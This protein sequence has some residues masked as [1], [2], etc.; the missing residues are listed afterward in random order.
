[1][2]QQI[3]TSAVVG[4]RVG[5]Q[6][7][8]RSGNF[9]RSDIADL[10]GLYTFFGQW[11]TSIPDEGVLSFLKIKPGS[12]VAW[13]TYRHGVDASGGRNNL[14]VHAFVF[15]EEEL[16]LMNGDPFVLEDA[17]CFLT[18][19]TQVSPELPA[20]PAPQS[21][22]GNGD[23]SPLAALSSLQI[24]I[25]LAASLC[26]GYSYFDSEAVTPAH[27][28]AVRY[29][30]PGPQRNR[31]TFYGLVTGIPTRKAKLILMPSHRHSPG[32]D[33]DASAVACLQKGEY[34]GPDPT[35][36][37]SLMADYVKGRDYEAIEG[38]AELSEDF[39]VDVFAPEAGEVAT[40]FSQRQEYVAKLQTETIL[41][42]CESLRTTANAK[43]IEGYRNEALLAIARRAVDTAK[44]EVP[45]Q[46]AIAVLG[47]RE[48]G[49][50]TEQVADLGKVLQ[51]VWKRLGDYPLL[52]PDL[53]ESHDLYFEPA[54]A[55]IGSLLREF[56]QYQESVN[57]HLPNA[58]ERVRY[59]YRVIQAAIKKPEYR[60]LTEWVSASLLVAAMPGYAPSQL[61][62]LWDQ[63]GRY[64]VAHEPA[65]QVWKSLREI[66]ANDAYAR[67][68]RDLLTKTECVSNWKELANWIV[69]SSRDQALFETVA[70]LLPQLCGDLGKIYTLAERLNAGR[71]LSPERALDMLLIAAPPSRDGGKLAVQF[72]LSLRL[73]TRLLFLTRYLPERRITDRYAWRL[74][75]ALAPRDAEEARL[76][77]QTAWSYWPEFPKNIRKM[78]LYTLDDTW[79]R[80]PS[81]GAKAL[82][83]RAGRKKRICKRVLRIT[84]TALIVVSCALGVT[85]AVRWLIPSGTPS[86]VGISDDWNWKEQ[87]K[88][89]SE[90]DSIK[91]LKYS[92][93]RREAICEA[94][95]YKDKR[96][97]TD[98]W[99]HIYK[100]YSSKQPPEPWA[101]AIVGLL[102]PTRT[103]DHPFI[104]CDHMA[105]SAARKTF[106]GAFRKK[107]VKLERTTSLEPD[108]AWYG[109]IDSLVESLKYEVF[110]PGG[111]EPII[112]QIARDERIGPIWKLWTEA[113]LGEFRLSKADQDALSNDEIWLLEI[114]AWAQKPG[115]VATQS[116]STTRTGSAARG[117]LT[118][119]GKVTKPQ[120]ASRPSRSKTKPTSKPSKSKTKP[121]SK[122]SKLETKPR[123][124]QSKPKPKL[125]SRPP[126]PKTKPPSG[127]PT[128]KP[129][130]TSRQS[131][132]KIKPGR[133]T[134]N[135]SPV[136]AT[137]TD[138]TTT[139]PGE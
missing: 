31:M 82:L 73:D 91:I 71:R 119:P 93:L 22:V 27:I 88:E 33:S 64:V 111:Q 14:W 54:Q 28:R 114:A 8:A 105:L 98:A 118:V 1:M 35:G 112:G 18:P 87:I 90:S 126:K 131:E 24:D 60:G 49:L 116:G 134:G 47:K 128:S 127:Q 70:G 39:G 15:S 85:N 108:H 36:Y 55:E 42:R 12:Y 9:T 132:S 110:P 139:K 2:E 96:N 26:Q 120:P 68:A 95:I 122:P 34:S 83:D 109:R 19:G 13:R 117:P 80:F 63:C 58:E 94:A 56:P 129:K 66:P 10:E 101:L 107:P 32:L 16:L 121:T 30:V 3:Y 135:T 21:K 50:T 43:A 130:P 99:D 75:E 100:R 137:A 102:D 45:L 67:I 125:P 38:L 123:S 5:F 124:R 17:D 81:S 6:T 78:L 23:L 86:R 76:L 104:L 37:A 40:L 59:W 92:I 77:V 138:A 103:N 41:K 29:L 7:I 48:S 44:N 113:K 97:L 65:S 72:L 84:V 57:A 11:P 79:R 51:A 20:I 25:L 136:E 115:R 46:Q 133:Q 69:W 4:D 52:L 74:F 62:T 89:T 61:S 53:L 106:L